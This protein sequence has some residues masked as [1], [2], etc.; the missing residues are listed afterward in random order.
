MTEPDFIAD[1]DTTKSRAEA[2]MQ[3]TARE[4]LLI[5]KL[6]MI[7]TGRSTCGTSTDLEIARDL[8]AEALHEIGWPCARKTKGE[9]HG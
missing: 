4:R 1:I 8:A 6:E 3:F 7:A 5:R 2:E 9:Q